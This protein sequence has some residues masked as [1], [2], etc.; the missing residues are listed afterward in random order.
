[1]A[2]LPLTVL[3]LPGLP[4]DIA[5]WGEW[6]KW[7]DDD[8]ARWALPISGWVVLLAV[9]VFVTISAVRQPVQLSPPAPAKPPRRLGSQP[10]YQVTGP[11]NV[12]MEGNVSVG[13]D[14]HLR[15]EGVSTLKA[16]GERAYKGIRELAADEFHRQQVRAGFDELLDELATIEG[17]AEQAH[18]AGKFPMNFI[19]PGE[20]WRRHRAML[21]RISPQVREKVAKV[22]IRADELNRT[23]E[24]RETT[25]GVK[26]ED[27]L[28]GFRQAIEQ[29]RTALQQARPPFPYP[30]DAE[31]DEAAKPPPPAEI[32]GTMPFTEGP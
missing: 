23:Y 26:P 18:R 2:S 29:A 10:A 22:Y 20:E 12:E 19:L 4:S 27:D 14:Q 31:T 25:R 21:S 1:M 13:F 24:E 28:A 32:T 8:V 30:A 3:S 9:L 6:L 15:A 17:R 5:G 16:S 7:V 11:A